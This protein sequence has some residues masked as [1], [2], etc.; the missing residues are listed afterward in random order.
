MSADLQIHRRR[1]LSRFALAACGGNTIPDPDPT[2][3]TVADGADA[4]SSGFGD[5][6]F[7]AGE[8][9]RQ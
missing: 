5:D 1:A 2:Y 7:G 3:D 6:S 4:R 8:H 9:V